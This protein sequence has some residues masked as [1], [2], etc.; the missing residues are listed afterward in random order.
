MFAIAA[1][2]FVLDGARMRSDGEAAIRY[3]AEEDGA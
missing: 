3:A 1:S 2:E